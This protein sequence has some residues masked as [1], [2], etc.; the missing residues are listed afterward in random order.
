MAAEEKVVARYKDGTLVKGY[1]N[2]FRVDADTIR[3]REP[4]AKEDHSV[5]VNDL[6]AVFFVKTFKGYR[7]RVERKA[8]GLRKHNG[9]KVYLKFSDRESLLGYIDGE[10]PWDKGYSLAK[11]GKKAKGFYLLPVDSA[12]NNSKIFVVGSAIKDITIM[13]A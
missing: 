11:L 13:V 1:V 6:K 7:D 2:N 5:P 3:L 12:S 10:V 9:R 8:F 4:K